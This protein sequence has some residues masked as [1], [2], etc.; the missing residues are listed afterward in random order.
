MSTRTEKIEKGVDYLQLLKTPS[1][2]YSYK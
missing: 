2:I 1:F